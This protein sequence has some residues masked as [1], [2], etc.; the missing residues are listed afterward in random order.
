MELNDQTPLI[1]CLEALKDGKPRKTGEISRITGMTRA[2]VSSAIGHAKS[3]GYIIV[4]RG[5]YN[6]GI[7][8]K[9]WKYLSK[10]GM[11]SK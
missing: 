4:R 10:K 2:Q 3:S 11:L 6:L 7:S 1:K 5:A 8:D 9:G